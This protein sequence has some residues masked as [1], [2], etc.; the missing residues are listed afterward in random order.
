MQPCITNI[1]V[2]RFLVNEGLDLQ[3]CRGVNIAL[4]CQYPWNVSMS[5]LKAAATEGHQTRTV[6]LKTAVLMG[7]H[8]RLAS[9]TRIV[10]H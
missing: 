1:N 9:C 10:W 8:S 5:K 3:M 7:L 2:P 6:Q 4:S